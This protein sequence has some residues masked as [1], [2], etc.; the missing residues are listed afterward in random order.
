[1]TDTAHSHMQRPDDHLV[2]IPSNPMAM[3]MGAIAA[4]ATGAVVGSAAGPVG[5]VVGAIVGAVIGGL[6]SDAIASAVG[7]VQDAA[8][9][10][11]NHARHAEHPG[12]NIGD[13]GPAY[14]HGAVARQRQVDRDHDGPMPGFGQAWPAERGPSQLA[15]ADAEPAIRDAWERQQARAR[16]PGR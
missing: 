8:Y 14:S 1:M 7:E 4:G 11:E 2:G 16:S 3:G 12:R 5:T 10:R 6:G 15:W 9:W 13:F